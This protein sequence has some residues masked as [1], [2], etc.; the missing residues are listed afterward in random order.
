MKRTI[1]CLLVFVFTGCVFAQ[2][3]NWFL[4]SPPPTTQKLRD[5]HQFDDQTAIF[6]GSGGTVIKTT[7]RGETW[8]VQ[9][10]GIYKELYSVFFNNESTG[11]IAGGGTIYKSTDGGDT[12]KEKP[13]GVDASLKAVH[14]IDANTGWAVGSK[15]TIIKTID[16]GETW[17]SQFS[18]TQTGSLDNVW[19]IDAQTGMAAGWDPEG[20]L[21][22]TTDGGQT[23]SPVNFPSAWIKGMHFINATE[24]WAVGIR[25][26]T[27]SASVDPFGNASYSIF[28]KQATVWKTTDGGETWEETVF[29]SEVWLNGVYFEDENTGWAAG[30]GGT[31]IHTDNGG[32][33]WT[34]QVNPF[35]DQHDLYAIQGAGESTNWSAGDNGIVLQTTNDGALWNIKSGSGT[36][37]HL[38]DVTFIDATTGWA[39]GNGSI[40]H[41]DDG[42][43][44]WY[45]Q[46]GSGRLHGVHFIDG[47]TGWAVGSWSDIFYTTDGGSNWIEQSSGINAEFYDVHFFNADQGWAVG[48]SGKI[49]STV[50]GGA[51]W[52][53]QDSGTS[54]SLYSIC[55]FDAATGWIVGRNGRILATTTGGQTWEEQVS[56]VTN[57]INSVY[58]LDAQ[59]G[60]AVGD[61]EIILH[62]EDG[63]INWQI[64]QASGTSSQSLESVYFLDNMTG[65]AAG[66][67]GKILKTLDGGESWGIQESGIS[68]GLNS[69]FFVDAE[70]GWTVGSNGTILKTI[71]GGGPAL[72]VPALLSP[73]DGAD[74]VPVN[75]ALTWEPLNG[76]LSYGVQVSGNA[77]FTMLV[78]DQTGILNNAYSPSTLDSE[79]EYYWRINA[80]FA[81][82]TSHWSNAWRFTTADAFM[83]YLESPVD[84]ATEISTNPTFTWHAVEGAISYRIQVSRN[85]SF[86]SWSNE[87]DEE[88]ILGTSYTA[89]GLNGNRN[90]Y[91]RVQT[92]HAGGTSDWS[93]TWGFTTG[94]PLPSP[95]VLVYPEDGDESV[96]ISPFLDWDASLQADTYHL[97]V[98]TDME[99]TTLIVDDVTITISGKQIGPLN[100]ETNYYWH[101]QAVNANG[102]SGFSESRRFRTVPEIIV[103]PD[104][105]LLISPADGA[106]SISVTPVLYWAESGGAETY[107]LQVAAD[108]AYTTLV[109]DDATITETEKEVGPLNN[110]TTFYW[111]VRAAN[112]GGT[113]AYSVTRQ[114]TTGTEGIDAPDVP[115]LNSPSDGDMSVSIVP[116]LE[117]YAANRA[118]TYHLQVSTDDAFSDLVFDDASITGTI[119]QIGPLDLLTTYYWHVQ[120]ANAGGTSDYS[121]T[122]Q[123]ETG[124]EST[125][126]QTLDVGVW[127]WWKSVFFL[128]EN[129][130]WLAG[131]GAILKTVDGGQTW[132]DITRN[133]GDFLEDIFFVDDQNGWAVGSDGLIIN[134]SD[135]GYNW[136]VQPGDTGERLDAVHFTDQHNGWA[137]G[138]SMTIIH[139]SDGG[140]SWNTQLSQ[141]M[142]FLKDIYF[143]NN[144]TGWAAGQG[145]FKTTD[146][147]T[148]WLIQWEMDVTV[149]VHFIDGQT[150]WAAGW[151]GLILN[152]S[153]GGVTWNEQTSV[154]T[155]DLNDIYFTDA[156]HGWAVGRDGTILKTSDGGDY[157]NLS[158][159][160]T[161]EDLFSVQFTDQ[162]N[163]W[164]VGAS[165]TV[166]KTTTGGEITA[167]ASDDP[168]QRVRPQ[169]YLLGQNYPNP[170]NPETVIPFHL[171][172]ATHVLLDIYDLLGRRIITLLQIQLPAGIHKVT[173][174]GLNQYGQ[175]VPTGMYIYR[176]ETNQYT[177]MRK[178]ILAK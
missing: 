61:K 2:G 118:Q 79:M 141:P 71:T 114:F 167:I 147:G 75:T 81:E 31:L 115:I 68:S 126:W 117:W 14:F 24:G 159:S 16:G 9:S 76:A 57:H 152:T 130:G 23:W 7:D 34:Q 47:N 138:K 48:G 43:M 59:K 6:V 4:Q 155:N 88:G 150:G 29:T 103:A 51:N 77:D 157:W 10:L 156:F 18:T 177:D 91:W 11:W 26:T 89:S 124:S 131:W 153:D 83:P 100:F 90:Y 94:L 98:A 86:S 19:F 30:E 22:R 128:D 8:T 120:A 102:V 80:V 178:M 20:R 125:G 101:V 28:G 69:V 137:A 112:A 158:A 99:F 160:G 135:G 72:G 149:A 172:E 82:G 84:G 67:E 154:V 12:W 65:W 163:G 93:H 122:W 175:T 132:I 121:D 95:P 44:T 142:R 85:T 52:H 169:I 46:K 109:F 116:V 40:I 173:W 127:S 62:T 136:N 129:N 5:V 162:A 148:N 37:N 139:T 97:Q 64:Q 55:F 107:H 119:Q 45:T 105:P 145:I 36:L 143:V 134:T 106:E 53:E 60:W 78:I 70:T 140:A 123:F 73:A 174:T 1:S 111:H 108:A 41:T 92:L 164:V 166:L 96:P 133:Q 170:F 56:G 74:K 33:T 35:G 15:R 66:R 161:S 38:Y 13:D 54:S 151:D 42:G 168:N 27:I 3:D 17:E 176:I 21:F 50:D 32:Q 39:V 58:F 104:P 87:I 49:L 113:S 110:M 165:G 171:P 146:G 144:Q 25:A 63:G